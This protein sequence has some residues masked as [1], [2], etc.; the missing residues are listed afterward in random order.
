MTNKIITID[1]AA[2]LIP[3]SC[4]LALGGLTNYRRPVQ[5]AKALLCRYLETG[6]PNN[7]TLLA[8]TGGLESDLLVGAGMVSCVRTCYFGLEIFGLAP[9]FTYLANRGEIEITEETEASISFGLRANLAGVGFMPGRGWLGTD[10][11]RLRPDVKSIHDPYSGEELIAFPAIYPEIAIIHALSADY[12]G[13]ALIGDNKGFDSEL[14]LAADVV[15]ITA[16][17]VHPTLKKVDIAGPF[18]DFVVL[19]PYGALPT[20]CHPNYALDGETLLEYTEKVSDPI[21]FNAFVKKFI[22]T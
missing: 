3:S 8:F 21:S 5:F 13:N 22:D 10:L 7:L 16:E 4:M 19:S 12:D 2:K 1:E 14:A 6:T 11:P 20:S 17:E 15:I 9:M 18:I